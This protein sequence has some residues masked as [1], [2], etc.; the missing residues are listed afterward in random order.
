MGYYLKI[1]SKRS[2]VVTHNLLCLIG[3]TT[4]KYHNSLG[5]RQTDFDDEAI[6]GL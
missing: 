2:L 5:I 4:R 3:E 6:D 1:T